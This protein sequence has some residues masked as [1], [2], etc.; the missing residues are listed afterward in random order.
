WTKTLPWPLGPKD[1]PDW[2][3]LSDD[4]EA[5]ATGVA[6]GAE[7][8]ISRM[9][10]RESA[11]TAASG[12]GP[13]VGAE[14]ADGAGA[15]TAGAET[16]VDGI[17]TETQKAKDEAIIIG[18]RTPVA[19]AAAILEKQGVVGAAAAALKSQ[20]TSEL[21][22]KENATRNI[23]F[24]VSKEFGQGIHDV[25]SGVRHLAEELRLTGETELRKFIQGGGK[26]GKD[27][28]A[29][30]NKAMHDKNP[31]VRAEARRIKA[32]IDEGVKPNTK[33]AGVKAGKDV[34]S[35]LNSQRGPVGTAATNLAKLVATRIINNIMSHRS[36]ERAEER[37][38]QGRQ[39]GGV[40]VTGHAY[41]VGERRPEFFVPETT[42]RVYPT[43]QAGMEALGGNMGDTNVNLQTYGLPM[44]A[45]TPLEVAMQVRRVTR[46]IVEPRDR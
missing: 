44:M 31:A 40:V 32:I 1:A 37:A 24:L 41:V 6:E 12:V 29:A 35:G 45:Q 11:S 22:P 9:D 39:S 3:K 18:G 21:T 19:L 10:L 13:A 5:G 38:A 8:G 26:V 2:A 7:K 4:A 42:G 34:V 46:G 25:R 17:P 36:Q 20:M 27:A 16:M 14:L 30:L 23:G 28:I 15:V 43:V 33:P